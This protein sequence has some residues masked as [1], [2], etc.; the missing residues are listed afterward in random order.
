MLEKLDRYIEILARVM[1]VVAMIIVCFVLITMGIMLPYHVLI[2]M[3]F[4]SL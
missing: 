4:I 3:G 2:V 1:V